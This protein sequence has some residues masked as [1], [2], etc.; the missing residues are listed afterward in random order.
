VTTALVGG[1]LVFGTLAPAQASPV[2]TSTSV[3]SAA[4]TASTKTRV[5]TPPRS[6]SVVAG[7]K[8]TFTAKATGRSLSYQWYVKKP[9]NT[10]YSKI[11]GARKS[12]YTLRPSSA[13]DGARYRVV[14]SG[15]RGTVTSKSAVLTVISRPRITE[16][17]GLTDSASAATGERLTWEVR[18]SGNALSYRWD[19]LRPGSRTWATV[20]H[21]KVYS[22]TAKSRL[23]GA[24]FRVTISNAAGKATWYVTLGVSSSPE[25]PFPARMYANG[26]TWAGRF[27]YSTLDTTSTP[28]GWTNVESS[29][30]SFGYRCEIPDAIQIGVRTA[31]GSVYPAEIP[32]Y[33]PFTNCECIEGEGCFGDAGEDPWN[34]AIVAQVPTEKLEGATWQLT[35]APARFSPAGKGWWAISPLPTD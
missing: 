13:R 8:V 26:G 5:V 35:S 28:E 15:A 1:A 10:W 25:D 3:A 6:T 16:L 11:S 17:V 34:F 2:T 32:S 30:F 12:S 7:K 24:E 31:D 29:F 9:G 22:V 20:S 18:A 19:V 14:V 4:T 33:P 21:K 23:H 27:D